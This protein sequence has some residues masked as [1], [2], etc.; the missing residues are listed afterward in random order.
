[1]R[2]TFP[3]IL[4]GDHQ[5]LDV[6][7]FQTA[8]DGKEEVTIVTPFDKWTIT[9]KEYACMVE[10]T[11]EIWIESEGYRNEA[12]KKGCMRPESAAVRRLLRK[13]RIDREFAR[14]EAEAKE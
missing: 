5:R 3:L 10:G 6:E 11:R 8:D 14:L 4:D 2:I 7:H 1:M 12:M 9:R 13:R